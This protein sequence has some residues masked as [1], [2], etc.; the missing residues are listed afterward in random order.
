MFDALAEF[1]RELIVERNR[2]GL[3]AARVQ[4]RLVGGP[5]LV[6]AAKLARALELR[7]DG[8]LSMGEIAKTIGVSRATL[9]RALARETADDCAVDLALMAREPRAS[10]GACGSR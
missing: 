3:E 5:R 6:T 10:T 8:Q 1:E 7:D 2:A 9:Y 4:G